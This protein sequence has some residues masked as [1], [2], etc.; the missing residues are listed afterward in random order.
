MRRTAHVGATALILLVGL[1]SAEITLAV[2]RISYQALRRTVRV[3]DMSLRLVVPEVA[4]ELDEI[5]VTGTAG[6]TERRA[7]GNASARVSAAR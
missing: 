7:L 6:A 4:V 3:G 5:I 2:P 1:A